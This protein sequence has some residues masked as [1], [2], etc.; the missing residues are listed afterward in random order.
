[1]EL[2]DLLDEING[3]MYILHNKYEELKGKRQNILDQ[4]YSDIFNIKIGD[5][6]LQVG[7]SKK[8]I[9]DGFL[10]DGSVDDRPDIMG[11]LRLP[12]GVSKKTR[13]FKHDQWETFRERRGDINGNMKNDGCVSEVNG[14]F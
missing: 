14:N 9:L 13:W 1:M 11:R 12:F 5:D 10:Q 8:I 3:E 2:R 7:I 6:V 4:Y